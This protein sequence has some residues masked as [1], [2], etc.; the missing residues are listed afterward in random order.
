[1]PPF[2][3]TRPSQLPGARVAFYDLSFPSFCSPSA[4]NPTPEPRAPHALPWTRRLA[5]GT[6]PFSL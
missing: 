4:P 5:L 6:R 1:M 3:E 2:K